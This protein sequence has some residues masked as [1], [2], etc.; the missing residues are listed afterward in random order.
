MGDRDLG[1]CSTKPDFC[2]LP[3]LCRVAFEAICVV[4]I[5]PCS[6]LGFSHP[7][8]RA[9]PCPASR[10]FFTMFDDACSR[11]GQKRCRCVLGYYRWP[12]VVPAKKTCWPK[13][14]P[15]AAWRQ[16]WARISRSFPN[17]GT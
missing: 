17:C 7:S 3:L 4:L 15:I 6:H 1:C 14:K 8:S 2:S 9:P 5:P 11:K 13:E 10:A 12:T 16:Q